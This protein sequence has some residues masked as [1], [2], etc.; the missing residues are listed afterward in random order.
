MRC[1]TVRTRDGADKEISHIATSRDDVQ[2]GA[3]TSAM[4]DLETSEPIIFQAEF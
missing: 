3:R 1:S 4:L 2:S